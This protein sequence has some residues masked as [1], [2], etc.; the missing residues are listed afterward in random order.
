M[1]KVYKEIKKDEWKRKRERLNEEWK[2]EKLR[3]QDERR[4]NG[5]TKKEL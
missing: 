1:G 3:K 5:G 2:T 4:M